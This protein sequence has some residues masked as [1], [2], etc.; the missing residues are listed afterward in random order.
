[1]S[2]TNIAQ[3]T[4][5]GSGRTGLGGSGREDV[6]FHEGPRGIERVVVEAIARRGGRTVPA[7][8][9]R[10]ALAFFEYSSTK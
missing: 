2:P 1:M 10:R 8:G 9:K 7:A 6:L 4:A 3:E 5:Q